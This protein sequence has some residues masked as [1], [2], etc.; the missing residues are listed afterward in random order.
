MLEQPGME[1]AKAAI[2]IDAQHVKQVVLRGGGPPVSFHEVNIKPV[3]RFTFFDQSHIVGMDIPQ[4][5]DAKAAVT[6]TKGMVL[7]D[8]AQACWRM[9]QI[10]VGQKIQII[11][12]PEVTKLV[13]EL[14]DGRV[15][16]TS[17]RTGSATAAATGDTATD[18]TAASDGTAE[19][20]VRGS[21][22]ATLG[23][24][25]NWLIQ[26][27]LE[28]ET[29]TNSMLLTQAAQNVPRR[30]ALEWLRD[31][32]RDGVR[33]G[34][35]NGMPADE[36][37][38]APPA[39]RKGETADEQPIFESDFLPMPHTSGEV[40]RILEEEV[41]V[42]D[43]AI[44]SLVSE[45]SIRARL[46]EEQKFNQLKSSYG[47][48]LSPRD[49]V[50]VL[51]HN[52]ATAQVH[53]AS[54]GR[55]LTGETLLRVVCE[56]TKLLRASNSEL[57]DPDEGQG[58]EGSAKRVREKLT[59]LYAVLE[60]IDTKFLPNHEVPMKEAFFGSI[61]KEVASN[62]S[63]WAE[64]DR[65]HTEALRPELT[66]LTAYPL[67]RATH[68]LAE[69][70]DADMF[71]RLRALDLARN[72]DR[73]SASSLLA[74]CLRPSL[75][76]PKAKVGVVAPTAEAY[77][78]FDELFQPIL[79][80]AQPG[81]TPEQRHQPSSD[82][83]LLAQTHAIQLG[84]RAWL[85][86]DPT[87]FGWVRF[88]CTRNLVNQP[89]VPA[90]T[91]AD[92]ANV[93][94]VVSG[95]IQELLGEHSGT[96]MGHGELTRVALTGAYH[97]LED[98]EDD[99]FSKP[100]HDSLLHAA[101][102]AAD[103]P[104]NRGWFRN[105][106]PDRRVMIQVN[107]SD[108]VRLETTFTGC[109][110]DETSGLPE[111]FRCWASAYTA[112]A[113]QLRQA[114]G[115]NP[116]A[117]DERFGWLS[118]DPRRTGSAFDA[119]LRIKLFYGE[120]DAADNAGCLTRETALQVV[121]PCGLV[122]KDVGGCKPAPGDEVESVPLSQALRD[123]K[124]VFSQAEL[125]AFKLHLQSSS[126][127]KVGERRQARYFVPAEPSPE[128]L[129]Q[130]QRL[131]HDYASG[132]SAPKAICEAL[133]LLL[134]HAP[135]M[136]VYSKSK[137]DAKNKETELEANAWWELSTVRCLGSTEVD[138]V[139]CLLEGAAKLRE[140]DVLLAA[141]QQQKA[142]Q[143]H[144]EGK[145]LRDLRNEEEA[146]L[147]AGY[148]GGVVGSVVLTRSE[149]TI[150]CVRIFREQL[151]ED[152]LVSN[153]TASRTRPGDALREGYDRFRA[154]LDSFDRFEPTER[155]PALDAC[156]EDVDRAAGGGAEGEA[157]LN[158]T[159][160]QEQEQQQQQEEEEEN[161][162]GPFDEKIVPV[163]KHWS[164]SLLGNPD[165]KDVLRP[166]CDLKIRPGGKC[167]LF[168]NELDSLRF[169]P[170]WAAAEHYSPMKRRLRNIHLI[171]HVSW[172]TDGNSGRSHSQ[173]C[174]I[175]LAEAEALVRH[176]DGCSNRLPGR[177]MPEVLPG[178]RV[179]IESLS[180]IRLIDYQAKAACTRRVK[181]F[182]LARS[183]KPKRLSTPHAIINTGDLVN[184]LA[185]PANKTQA[186][187]LYSHDLTRIRL[188]FWN[189]EFHFF[190]A[191]LLTLVATLHALGFDCKTKRELF[192]EML[193]GRRRDKQETKRTPVDEVIIFETPGELEK[194]QSMLLKAT[195]RT[196]QSARRSEDLA[197]FW[198]QMD[199][200]SND[201]LDRSELRV[202]C[203]DSNPGG[204]IP[205][206]LN[207]RW[208]WFQP[209]E[210]PIGIDW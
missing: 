111:G 85:M 150:G 155:R 165:D 146:M 84:G 82:V 61:F 8:F 197:D 199:Q 7:R 83:S 89:F 41:P 172:A 88:T 23:D 154:L 147:Y 142:K 31:G 143:A 13:E 110:I 90:C 38:A 101:G 194:L 208:P 40:E 132:F 58:S 99:A 200:N 119:A 156:L 126:F 189:N 168:K 12:V 15:S 134:T 184:E 192:Q 29:L 20:A 191:E 117:R 6:I 63:A 45:L 190:K 5:V 33:G 86:K 96:H 87:A 166:L 77:A 174:I 120:E 122:W 48:I 106:D 64:Y 176:F 196:S 152:L 34:V 123:G 209:T 141:I 42:V 54:F 44:A 62:R 158:T 3:D 177:L 2:Y 188:R 160:V 46:E 178:K 28:A 195:S 49:A 175:T 68:A 173:H 36:P 79:L 43:F 171:V 98:Q 161:S 93:A 95:A 65:L 133:G 170:N 102:A 26:A 198:E 167:N 136:F 138:L 66:D 22:A 180:G 210:S 103:W 10:E 105:S 24:V 148:G 207:L 149:K 69:T 35:R 115:G 181:S 124:R 19:V 1:W 72:D 107:H 97:S 104:R 186:L 18:A 118:F 114:T 179:Q 113:D 25:M 55:L 153:R 109:K 135:K 202:C 75:R 140:R 128:A 53:G 47:H 159:M 50:S 139:G 131:E 92:L 17:R 125:D 94:A 151:Q 67:E 185:T 51:A 70:L 169:S 205:G 37:A 76:D 71:G 81:L 80:K 206:R 16:G 182:M 164:P 130:A 137:S 74:L 204:W 121:A 52:C 201:Y 30:Q 73:S 116:F 57:F 187:E 127:V 129:A 59:V 112:L 144:V 157:N 14:R 60:D 91:P 163:V 21:S 56:A 9:R 203:W 4:A 108:H 27:S 39:P 100:P 32:V 193:Q 183:P 11:A 145:R 78:L 162:F